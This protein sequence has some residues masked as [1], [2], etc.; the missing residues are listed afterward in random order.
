MFCKRK[1]IK[2]IRCR[3]Y[4]PKAQGKVERSH[5]I[6]RNKIY[7]D[8]VKQK[9]TGVNWVKNLPEY[10][11]CLNN[12]K[13]EELGWKSAFEIYFGRK[14]N[15]LV[16]EGKNYDSTIHARRTIGPS[17]RDYGQ[18]IQNTDSWRKIASKADDR[19]T[20]RMLESDARR[21][22]Y[23]IYQPGE[24]V[25]VR[26][27]RKRGRFTR[28]YRVLVGKILKRFRDEATYKVRFHMPGSKSPLV[29]KFRVEDIT[30]CPSEQAPACRDKRASRRKFREK[31]L[32][33]L[34][35]NDRIE[36]ITQ[37]G[38]VVMYDPIGDGNCQFSALA[39][40]LRNIGIHRSVSTLRAEVISYL[41]RNDE[42]RGISLELFV[43]MPWHQYVMQ[44]A[45]DG[46]YGD[47]IT[48]RAVSNMFNV[49]VTVVSTIGE[50]AQVDILPEH[51]HPIKR[52]FLGH[53][54]EGQGDH[55]LSIKSVIEIDE[56]GEPEENGVA[57]ELVK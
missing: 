50:E 21:H 33:P 25:F 6:L 8:M 52:I 3:P 53:F 54:A 2:M 26:V 47:E 13:R 38:Y 37:Q 7:Y 12:D 32:I 18:Q 11:K 20:K 5:R 40:A 39:F 51:S 15:E 48:L 14:S 28:N 23:K 43:G 45:R 44:M 10:M 1:R 27:G 35:R 29:Q 9:K 31:F 49:Q 41:D 19:M 16:N 22:K 57:D 24:K 46:T 30:D 56:E 55:Y 17:T 4:N 42:M 34:K 36:Q